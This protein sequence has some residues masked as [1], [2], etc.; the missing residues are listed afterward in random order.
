MLKDKITS[1]VVVLIV[2]L[3][4]PF[5]AAAD[6]L[7]KYPNMIEN[8]Y[9]TRGCTPT[10]A[11][12]TL[13]Y[14]D[15][16][17][18]GKYIHFG[19]LIDYYIS[20]DGVNNIPNLLHEL[21]DAMGTTSNG[22]T[23]RSNVATGIERVTNEIN[24]YSFDARTRDFSTCG[25]DCWT[26]V[27]DEIN[28]GRPFIWHVWGNPSG[29]STTA[30]GYTDNGY[31]VLYDT[32]DNNPRMPY[33][34]YREN[35]YHK[36]YRYNSYGK[37]ITRIIPAPWAESPS[38][39]L[40]DDPCGGERLYAGTNYTIRWY[41]FGS[42]ITHVN[43]EYSIDNGRNWRTIISGH[44]SA[45]E[46]WKSYSWR[47]PCETSSTVRVRVLG[48]RRVLFFNFLQ[49]ADGS[50]DECSIIQQNLN[51]P[52]YIRASSSSVCLSTAY[53]ISWGSVT[54]VSGYDIEENGRWYDVG[55]VTSRTCNPN[56]PGNYTYRVRAKNACNTGASS[57]SVTVQVNSKPASAPAALLVSKDT[58]FLNESFTIS[59]GEVANT[60]AY[61]LSQNGSWQEVGGITSYQCQLSDS[62]T[63]YFKVRSFNGC[64]TGPESKTVS[65]FVKNI[66]LSVEINVSPNPFV[67]SR[68]H[69]LI[70]FFGQT[71]KKAK[72]DIYD[73]AGRFIQ[74]IENKSN[75]NEIP[76][77]PTDE[78]GH[79]LASG[80]YI[81]V[82]ETPDGDIS[83]GKFAIIK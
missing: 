69:D 43:L 70:T 18:G 32:W 33:T 1:L 9:W 64:G 59:W 78:D 80:V 81:W 73:K 67:P 38:D 45:G 12:M 35:W 39:V 25:D 60:T 55:N 37:S 48:V 50:F 66:P 74:T 75:L 24:N 3:S 13:S 71:A 83:R 52:S 61:E 28:T 2:L 7:L 23:L 30:W 26:D 72:I 17:N 36:E 63:Y 57:S 22:N 11:A 15:Y 49:G 41:Q 8:Y 6:H 16:Y 46:G 82:A 77:K 31:V 44:P 76:W 47:V 4:A 58:V 68:G 79:W 34:Q 14:W 42:G 54:G 29:H 20:T 10:A 56:N 51:A 40:L 21:A 19:K 53:S 5:V 27:K 65:V 62:G